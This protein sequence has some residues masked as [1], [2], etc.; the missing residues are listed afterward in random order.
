M[1]HWA[2]SHIRVTSINS[3]IT[4]HLDWRFLFLHHMNLRIRG[5]RS[6]QHML[7]KIEGIKH[8]SR[9]MMPRKIQCV[10]V[11][12]IT[13]D[14][15]PINNIETYRCK[16]LRNTHHRSC[17]RMKRPSAATSTWLRNI[18]RFCHELSI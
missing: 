13:V 12:E 1:E 7:I 8:W 15:R 6:K 18:H 9:R 3:A 16:N 2:V 11:V 14:F 4:N 17:N 5:M 10:K